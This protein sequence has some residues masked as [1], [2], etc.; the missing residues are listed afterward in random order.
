MFT[1]CLCT[2]YVACLSVKLDRWFPRPK[3]LDLFSWE[4]VSCNRAL[5][6]YL[7]L[8]E[9]FLWKMEKKLIHSTFRLWL[10]VG[11]GT[12]GLGLHFFNSFKTPCVETILFPEFSRRNRQANMSGRTM[13]VEKHRLQL[14]SSPAYNSFLETTENCSLQIQRKY[15]VLFV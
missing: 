6:L 1:K 10:K 8:V 12:W 15:Q 7:C 9:L 2:I 4:R 14:T 5:Q 3:G 13:D 11:R